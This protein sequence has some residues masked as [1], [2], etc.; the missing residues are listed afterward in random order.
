MNTPSRAKKH[1]VWALLTLGCVVVD[2]AAIV[3]LVE[4]VKWLVA[5]TSPLVLAALGAFAIMTARTLWSVYLGVNGAGYTSRRMRRSYLS[6][7]APE[8]QPESLHP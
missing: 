7:T 2:V 3:M 6:G 8:H 1:V 4:A 5:S